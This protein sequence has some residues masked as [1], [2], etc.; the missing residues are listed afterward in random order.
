MK[1]EHFKH[2]LFLKI[3]LIL[4]VGLAFR[5]FVSC[6]P[7]PPITMDY[8]M[9]KVVGIDNSG[10]YMPRFNSVDTMYS[11]AVAF[12]L[13]LYDSAFL[14]DVF[15]ANNPRGFFAFSKANALSIAENFKP[16]NK[17]DQ[18][19]IKTLFDIDSDIKAGD[20]VTGLM[21]YAGSDFDLYKGLDYAISKLNGEQYEP[22]GTVQLVFTKPV[23]NTMAG[24][25]VD[26]TLDN[27]RQIICFSETFTIITP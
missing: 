5:V 18:L 19:K 4:L 23:R 1:T 22:R 25:R 14:Y 21:L 7:P 27:G 24:F 6:T 20:D 10:R 3:A 8:N 16:L 2:S 17:V 11:D 26:I 13:V 15:V 12:N 9:A